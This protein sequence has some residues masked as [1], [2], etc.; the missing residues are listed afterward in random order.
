M[1]NVA[2][3]PS[4]L[5]GDGS[6]WSTLTVGDP[7]IIVKAAPDGSEVARYPGTVVA[8][9][10][11]EGWLVAR[12]VWTY[13]QIDVAGLTFCPEDV[14]AEW[15]S[16]RHDFNAFAIHAVDGAFKGWYANVT[17]PARLSAAESPPTL[18]WRDLYLDVIVLPDGS[19]IVCDE[20]EL[21]ASGLALSD[22]PLHARIL[23]A[24]SEI[25][26]RLEQRLPP[27]AAGPKPAS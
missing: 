9:A 13:R 10:D 25:L 3:Q 17:Y 21:A 20:D 16:P 15:F 14:L 22:P 27:F 8:Q 1:S 18:T 19:A 24:R 26:H 5:R 4:S 11:P 12:A 7:L 6:S 2:N 23:R